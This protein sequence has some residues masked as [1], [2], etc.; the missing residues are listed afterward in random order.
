MLIDQFE[1]AT[2]TTASGTASTNTTKYSGVVLKH[3]SIN[4]NTDGTTF[5]LKLTDRKDRIVYQ[6]KGLESP[7]NEIT[8]L[9]LRGIYTVNLSNASRD[10]TVNVLLDVVEM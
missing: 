9:P 7:Y 2:L 3:I 10:E 1:P 4:F 6:Q 5:D 8:D